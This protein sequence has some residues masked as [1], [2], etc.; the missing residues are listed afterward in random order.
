[1]DKLGP[2]PGNVLVVGASSHIGHAIASRFQRGG[3]AVLATYHRSRTDHPD[4]SLQWQALD[5]TDGNALDAFAAAI[6]QRPQR[7]DT[8]VVAAGSILGRSLADYPDRDIGRIMDVNF[9]GPARLL[10]R[11]QSAINDGGCVLMLASIS[12]ERGSYD[13]IYAA[14]KGAVIAFVKSMAVQAAPRVRYTAVAP[15]L[16]EGSGM[17]AAMP[18]ERRQHHLASTPVGRLLDIDALANIVFDLSQPH[19][20]HANGS[21]VRVNGGAYV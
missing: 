12:G 11:L 3:A 9:T 18:P 16:V 2:S 19:W 10:R 13:P 14:A 4:Q 8:V 1:M 7:F 21:C 5:L 6:L 15:G 17:H 20:A